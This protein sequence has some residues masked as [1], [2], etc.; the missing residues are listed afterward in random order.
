MIRTWHIENAVVVA[1]LI[2][3]A[4]V[5]GGTITEWIGAAAV[6]CGF[7]HGSIAERLRER[8][9]A[10][11]SPAVECYHLLGRFFLAREILWT[12][13]FVLLDAWSALVGCALFAAYPLW[14]RWWRARNP[15]DRS[16]C[17]DP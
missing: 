4:I 14:R 16:P 3:T 8:E 17:V 5:S 12:A 9:A 1:A 11:P 2:T 15:L 10:R 7:C 13:Y 6:F